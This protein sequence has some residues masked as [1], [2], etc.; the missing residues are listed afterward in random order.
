LSIQNSDKQS[1]E[2]ISEHSY[3]ASMNMNHYQIA[4]QEGNADPALMPD[5]YTFQHK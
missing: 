2:T 4:E 1:N 5:F 3:N